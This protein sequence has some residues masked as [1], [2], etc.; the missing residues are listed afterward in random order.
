MENADQS[1]SQVKTPASLIAEAVSYFKAQ[2]PETVLLFCV[3]AAVVYGLYLG[4][5]ALFHEIPRQIKAVTES[6]ERAVDKINAS[7]EKRSAED[8]AT[9]NKLIERHG[10]AGARDAH[11]L[12]ASPK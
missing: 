3:L 2:R 1:Q 7:H 6:H 9:I 11:N 12:A 8:H 4:G 5:S 10:I